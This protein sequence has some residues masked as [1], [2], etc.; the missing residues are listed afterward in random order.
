M[1]YSREILNFVIKQAKLDIFEGYEKLA[2]KLFE[3]YSD[4]DG[5]FASSD[6]I[7]ASIIHAANLIGKDIT[8]DLKIVGYDDI[9][10]ASIIV[11]PL[12]TIKQ[13]IEKMES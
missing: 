7:A 10:I 5:V 6:M 11:P 4:I 9:N 3:E 1:L 8:K 13:P 12:T 2:Y